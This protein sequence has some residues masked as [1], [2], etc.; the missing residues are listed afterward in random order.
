MKEKAR[1]EIGIIGGTGLYDPKLFE[2]VQSV[3]IVTPYGA[4]SSPIDV[5]TFMGRK[6]AFLPRHGKNHTYPPH[7][8]NYRANIWAMKEL[9]VQR[10][11]SPCAVGSLNEKMQ[12]GHLVI[13]DQFID[14]TKKR[15]Y[16]FYDGGKTVHI[17][18]ADPF[19]PQL[20][21]IFIE[22]AKAMKLKVHSNATYITIEGPRFS[23]R[24][25]SKYFKNF[26]DII[27]MT[28]NPECQLARELE[29]C[30]VSLATVTDLDV[31]ADKPVD[32]KEVLKTLK[33]NEDNIK[34]LLKR[35][36][37]KI[38]PQDRHLCSTALEEA[39]T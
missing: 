29:I 8:V 28:L 7:A 25:E 33:E 21:N 5:G 20:R 34:N 23:T 1:A 39:S 37:P 17:S 12:P 9:G 10:I 30:Y 11:I 18:A 16:T 36:V 27:G 6:V 15:D 26:A 22:E 38:P 13:P 3:K 19:C 4:P 2:D 24:A 32:I 14:F 35:A 31:W